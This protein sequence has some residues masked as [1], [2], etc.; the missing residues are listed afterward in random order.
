VLAQQ[1]CGKLK[2][3]QK[4]QETTAPNKARANQWKRKI[5]NA[6]QLFYL[7]FN[8]KEINKNIIYYIVK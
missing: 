5:N 1:P 2:R 6:M 4:Y 7:I 3:H 8:V